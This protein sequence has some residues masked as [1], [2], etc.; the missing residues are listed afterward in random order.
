MISICPCFACSTLMKIY[1]KPK[2]YFFSLS[3]FF[4]WP[5][6]FLSLS[7]ITPFS[8]LLLS[9]LL[10][11][12]L[13]FLSLL[14][15]PTFISVLYRTFF[16]PTIFFSSKLSCRNPPK[17]L[18]LSLGGPLPLIRSMGVEVFWEWGGCKAEFIFFCQ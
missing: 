18:G 8:P 15:S 13:Y 14:L 7:P 2:T 12:S 3:A 10:L 1:F 5:L 4:A 17:S 6:P 9:P 11:T 16:I